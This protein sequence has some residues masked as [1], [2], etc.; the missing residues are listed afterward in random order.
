MIMQSSGC[1]V[2]NKF[3]FTGIVGPTLASVCRYFALFRHYLG[4]DVRHVGPESDGRTWGRDGQRRLSWLGLYFAWGRTWGLPV[5]FSGQ[6][7]IGL[8]LRVFARAGLASHALIGPA[9]NREIRS[10]SH[11][12]G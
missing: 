3:L 7:G 12:T 9:L 5:H 4:E 6:L 11:S 2:V 1:I 8:E 10:T